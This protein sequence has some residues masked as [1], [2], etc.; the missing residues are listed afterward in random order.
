MHARLICIHFHMLT[1]FLLFHIWWKLLSLCL[2][3]C[4]FEGIT[5]NFKLYYDGQHYVGE[6]RFD[7]VQDLVADGLITF[8][9]EAKAADY[10]AALSS[11]SNYAESPYVAYNTQKKRQ[12]G[13]HKSTRRRKHNVEKPAE[14]KATEVTAN[15]EEDEDG[16]EGPGEHDYVNQ[17]AVPPRNKA[18]AE[19]VNQVAPPKPAPR[20]S[21]QQQKERKQEQR[22][23]EQQ[24]RNQ[25]QQEKKQQ[26]QQPVEEEPLP[27]P[28]PQP[29]QPSAASSAPIPASIPTVP[30]QPRSVEHRVTCSTNTDGPVSLFSRIRCCCFLVTIDLCLMSRLFPPFLFDLLLLLLKSRSQKVHS[31]AS[32]PRCSSFARASQKPEAAKQRHSFKVLFKLYSFSCSQNDLF[33]SNL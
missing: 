20:T 19:P 33:H 13:G 1:S 23:K 17:P 22:D 27:P 9:L 3:C 7:T 16:E 29:P 25:Q 32:D 15:G 26:Q 8:Y 11:Q 18:P 30:D 24:R 5:K 31:I 6:K 2:L 4:R 10:I 12:M 14:K 28:P 21:I